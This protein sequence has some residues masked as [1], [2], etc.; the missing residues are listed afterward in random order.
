MKMDQQKRNPAQTHVSMICC[1][2][3]LII[4]S[5]PTRN[6][7]S[8]DGQIGLTSASKKIWNQSFPYLSPAS[9]LNFM[10]F[11]RDMMRTSSENSM[12]LSTSLRTKWSCFG[13]S[14]VESSLVMLESL[15]VCSIYHLE[16]P[17]PN[18]TY[19]TRWLTK[20]KGSSTH[21]GQRK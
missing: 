1:N 21:E 6:W 18:C 3:I 17:C 19:L 10:D 5:T 14:G 4:Q 7:F 2:S 9:L 8:T 16:M 15:P 13:C 11:S 12:P 20:I